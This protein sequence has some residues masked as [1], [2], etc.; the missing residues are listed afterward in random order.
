MGLTAVTSRWL[1]TGF[2]AS[3]RVLVMALKMGDFVYIFICEAVSP[4]LLL[5]FTC[6]GFVEEFLTAAAVR[7]SSPTSIIALFHRSAYRPTLN[8]PIGHFILCGAAAEPLPTSSYRL[9]F[10]PRTLTACPYPSSNANAQASIG[11][12][13]H[14]TF[15]SPT[16]SHL[17]PKH[18]T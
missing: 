12:R 6:L 13:A 11:H 18:K 14:L 2:I 10:C 16:K 1:T 4:P 3:W 8:L 15:T 9:E 5:P 7:H 17:A